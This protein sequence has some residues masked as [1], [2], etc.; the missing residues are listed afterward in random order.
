MYSLIQAPQWYPLFYIVSSCTH[1][2]FINQ[3]LDQYRYVWIIPGWY[4]DQWWTDEKATFTVNCTD[5]KLAGFLHQQR[6][7]AVRVVTSDLS[8]NEVA[9][10]GIVRNVLLCLVNPLRTSC[11]GAVMCMLPVCN[12]DQVTTYFFKSWPMDWGELW[13]SKIIQKQIFLRANI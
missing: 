10:G 11:D 7:L 12:W 2:Q 13:A 4:P 8:G 5:E 3:E 6:V 1:H 9:I